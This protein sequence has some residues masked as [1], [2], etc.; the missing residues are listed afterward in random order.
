MTK[1]KIFDLRKSLLAEPD[2]VYAKNPKEALAKLGY[3]NVKRD[4]YGVGDIVV[5]GQRGSY[6]Y[7][8]EMEGK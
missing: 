1:Y 7:S 5:Y 8:W 4:F 3:A 6:V 2:I